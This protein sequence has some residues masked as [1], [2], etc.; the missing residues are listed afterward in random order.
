[1]ARTKK[2][3]N[4]MAVL[5]YEILLNKDYAE[6]E[7]WAIARDLWYLVVTKGVSEE[8]FDRYVAKNRV[9]TM[10]RRFDKE[11]FNR[12][13]NVWRDEQARKG[14]VEPAGEDERGDGKAMAAN[15]E[16]P[17]GSVRESSGA[18]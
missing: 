11:E 12:R 18:V 16:T 1:M 3:V 7:D 14:A 8:S 17:G 9:G 5:I 4:K 13:Y 2:T 10:L 15:G 6:Q